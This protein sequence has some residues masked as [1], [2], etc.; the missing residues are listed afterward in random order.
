MHR[1]K[2]VEGDGRDVQDGHRV[3]FLSIYIL[4]MISDTVMY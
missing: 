4:N 2:K 1:K 3:Y